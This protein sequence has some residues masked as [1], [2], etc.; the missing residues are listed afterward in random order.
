[1]SMTVE[2]AL[3]FLAD[4]DIPAAKAYALKE[5]LNFQIKTVEA[6]E[7]LKSQH[8]TAGDRMHEARSSPAYINI[9]QK[10][11][12]AVLEH[13]TLKNQR[14]TCEKRFEYWRSKNANRRQGGSL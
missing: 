12:D 7:A 13:E 2:E 1:M 14:S 11:E 3:Q 4:T 6:I 5:G 10:Y 9:A 8:K